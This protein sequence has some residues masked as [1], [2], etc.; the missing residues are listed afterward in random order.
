MLSV[1]ITYSFIYIQTLHHDFSHIRDV[2][3]ILCAHYFPSEML[4]GCHICVI[5]NS[6]RTSFFY[7][8]TLLYECYKLKMCT[9]YFVHI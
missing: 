8:Q 6:S 3:L 2:R 7:F 5:C 4:R 9:S 1:T